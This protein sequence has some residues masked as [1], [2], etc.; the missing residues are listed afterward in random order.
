MKKLY[1]YPIW[2]RLWH[3]LNA[4]IFVV[5]IVSGMS[6]H[7]AGSGDFLFSFE[8][9]MIAHNTSGIALSFLY[10]FYF[11]L[12]ISSGNIKHYLP[13]LRNFITR[14]IKQARF[15]TFGIFLGEPHPYHASEKEKFNPMQQMAYFF[16]VFIG[17]PVIIASGWF[18]MFPELAPDE[19]FGMGGVW[20]MAMLHTVM[21]FFLTI[22]MFVHIYLATTGNTPSEHFIAM[23]TGYHVVHEDHH[24]EEHEDK[25]PSLLT[26]PISLSGAFITMLSLVFIVLLLIFEFLVGTNNPYTRLITYIIIPSVLFLGLIVILIGWLNENRNKQKNIERRL[27]LLDFNRAKHQ[28]FFFLIS[29]VSFTIVITT[30]YGSRKAYEYT[31]SNSF[32]MEACHEV[33]EPVS[34]TYASS[35]HSKIACVDC[36]FTEKSSFWDQNRL[37]GLP[38]VY[39][40]ITDSYEKPLGAPTTYLRP[41]PEACKKCHWEE[42]Y[43]E[44]KSFK[45]DYFL[46]DEENTHYSITLTMK[47]G[48]GNRE[49]GISSGIHYHMGISKDILYIEPDNPDDAIPLVKAISKTDG[50]ETVYRLTGKQISPTAQFKKFDCIDC[51][52]RPSHV[53]NDPYQTI[54]AYMAYDKIN[55]KLPNIKK[56]GVRVLESLKSRENSIEEIK[57]A[58]TKYYKENY[59]NVPIDMRDEL[60]LAIIEL[61]AIYLKNYFPEMNANWKVYANHESHL[62]SKGCFRCHDGNH[63]NKAGEVLSND[64]NLCHTITTKLVAGKPLADSLNANTFIHP[65]GLDKDILNQYCS[66]CHNPK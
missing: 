10:L 6:L 33:M 8:V 14:S 39:M 45:R 17:F 44:Q 28:L 49:I 41:S 53:Y 50:K 54:N 58:L 31:E 47:V 30:I 46:S 21:G 52:N 1:L 42:K 11:I 62:Y 15:Y 63:V 65:G 19:I 37:S 26:N 55:S 66:D 32:C 13:S 12:N 34:V 18:L 3:W 59:P 23:F 40:T 61:N 4:L 57:N 7:Y 43:Y 36:H 38:Q 2:L 29:V 9:A 22:F 5:L 60:N 64:C 27:P 48:G 25:L 24:E 35:P 56:I 20:P 16:I 51:H